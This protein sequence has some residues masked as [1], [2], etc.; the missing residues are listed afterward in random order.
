M[1]DWISVEA[2]TCWYCGQ[3]GKPIAE[4]D[5]GVTRHQIGFC[6]HDCANEYE[7]ER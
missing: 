2:E 1:S 4:E 6:S 7:A 3:C 5:A